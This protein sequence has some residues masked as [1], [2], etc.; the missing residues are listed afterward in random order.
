MSETPVAPAP[1]PVPS[2]PE[3]TPAAPTGRDTNKALVAIGGIAAAGLVILAGVGG[4]AIGQYNGS[5]RANDIEVTRADSAIQGPDGQKG[6]D[7]Q[8]QQG[9]GMPGGM[10]GQ[11]GQD[12]RGTDPDGD[13]WTGGNRMDGQGNGMQGLGQGRML[14]NLPP[15]IQELLKQF[16]QGRGGQQGLPQMPTTPGAQ[17]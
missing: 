5:H 9:P 4:Y 15:Q 8:D 3:P 12:P 7:Q 6:Q 13:N 17:S 1:E 11:N 14:Q 2:T 10:N 16:M